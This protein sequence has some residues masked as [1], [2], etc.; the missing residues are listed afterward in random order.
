MK[1]ILYF[2]LLL[3]I[4]SPATAIDFEKDVKVVEGGTTKDSKGKRVMN[5]F[6]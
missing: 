1:I 5:L 4:C 3:L 6:A 2:A